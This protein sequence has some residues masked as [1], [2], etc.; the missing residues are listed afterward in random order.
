MTEMAQS[1]LPFAGQAISACILAIG[2]IFFLFPV[3]ALRHLKLEGVAEHPEAVG[4]ARS[5]F[6]GFLIAAGGLAL[7]ADLPPVSL[8]IA[9]S[10]SIASI[11]KFIH[12]AFDGARRSSVIA[13][14]LLVTAL[15]GV[16]AS[17]IEW[18]PYFLVLPL[19]PAGILPVI[20]ALITVLFG[21]ICFFA[22][23]TALHLMRLRPVDSA[24]EAKGEVRGTLAGFYLGTGLTVLFVGGFGAVLLLGLAWAMTAFGRIISMLSD[25][26]NNPFNWISL[27]LELV[28][29]L[30]PLGVV[31]GLLG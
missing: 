21:L 12:F 31:L 19:T 30:L 11:G 24:P 13:R 27:T 29:V 2:L 26:A 1:F 5:S 8:A 17:Q 3:G 22:P 15:A 4:E 9:A 7:A 10:L 20:S 18:Q 16:M 25:G 23:V 28:L 6:A 14:F